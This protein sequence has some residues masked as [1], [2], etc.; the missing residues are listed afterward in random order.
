MDFFDTLLA[1]VRPLQ[2]PRVWIDNTKS[3]PGIF[4]ETDRG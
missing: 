3:V 2:D 1:Y 4:A